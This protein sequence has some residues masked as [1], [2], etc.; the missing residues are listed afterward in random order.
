MMGL[1]DKHSLIAILIA[2]FLEELGIPMP[3]PTDL[4]IVLA[5]VKVAGSPEA[6]VRWFLL[7]NAAS[8]AG[9]SGLYM[10][11]HRGGRPL[12]DRYGRYIH[13]GPKQVERAERLLARGGWW[14]IAIGRAIPGLR[15]LAVISCGLFKVPFMR[16]LTAHIVGS[17]VYIGVFLALG[18]VFGPKVVELL[19]LP[20]QELR[21]IWLL[22]LAIGLPLL[23]AWL[24]YRGHAEYRVAPSR[25]RTLGAILLASFAGA[26]AMAAAWAAAA[27]F[28][29]VLDEPRPLDIMFSLANA[30]LGRGLRPSSAYMLAYSA[31]LML[32]VGVG[33][34]FY[35]LILPII[36]PRGTSLTRQTFGLALLCVVLVLSFLGPA[37]IA[38]QNGPIDRWW[39]AGG[40]QLGLA[41]LAGILCYSLTTACAR[42]LAIAILP[43]LRRTEP[44]PTAPQPSR[45][46]GALAGPSGDD[47]PEPDR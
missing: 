35:E 2:V 23:L 28:T 25:R 12:I 24:C 8:A 20:R 46:P 7:L 1:L 15:Y 40:P 13:M 4:L 41:L 9:A 32:C 3:I 6:F 45:P 11:I 17:S 14:S 27:T 34:A 29:A 36:T 22:A 18:S 43:S 47:W 21:L 37:L 44:I 5:G 33:V 39:A 26:T 38:S 19:H 31:L 30:L 10:I 16:F 42:V